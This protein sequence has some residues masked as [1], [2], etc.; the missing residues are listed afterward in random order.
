[1]IA[2]PW[3]PIPELNE[4]DKY[5]Y[6]GLGSFEA[7]GLPSGSGGGFISDP[8]DLYVMTRGVGTT[9]PPNPLPNHWVVTRDQVAWIA[10][11]ASHNLQPL[12]AAFGRFFV[13]LTG[14]QES[15]GFGGVELESNLPT[16]PGRRY[17]L[18]LWLGTQ[19][20]TPD[21]S[22]PVGVTVAVNGKD[23]AT[24]VQPRGGSGMKWRRYGC[25]FDA[26]SEQAIIEIRAAPV[27]RGGLGPPKLIGLDSVTCWAVSPLTRVARLLQ[28]P[29]G[30]F[31]GLFH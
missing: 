20:S 14:A 22:G 21:M 7:Y 15:P 31:R 25:F 11:G 16:D 18:A 28:L 6:H 5:G 27:D 8:N 2:M 29:A 10:G 9:I 13:D 17:W 30:T 19:E 23:V 12:S 24:H 4:I 26:D 1:V 3:F